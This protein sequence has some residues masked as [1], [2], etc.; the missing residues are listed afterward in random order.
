M[1]SEER[2]RRRRSEWEF[3]MMGKVSNRKKTRKFIS[4]EKRLEKRINKNGW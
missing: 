3:E 2:R 4:R 1:Q